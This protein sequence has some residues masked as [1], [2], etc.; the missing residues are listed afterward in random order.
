MIEERYKY[1]YCFFVNDINIYIF[2]VSN[3]SYQMNE[4]VQSP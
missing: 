1:L 3:N 4:K 2:V